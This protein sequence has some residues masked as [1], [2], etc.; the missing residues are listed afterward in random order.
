MWW[1]VTLRNRHGS[2]I[3][4]G[5]NN[6]NNNRPRLYYVV[7][8]CELKVDMSDVTC[9]CKIL[10]SLTSHTRRAWLPNSKRSGW[11]CPSIHASEE[12]CLLSFILSFSY[13][14][15]SVCPSVTL[16]HYFELR[17]RRLRQLHSPLSRRCFCRGHS[18]LQI[19]RLTWEASMGSF[20]GTCEPLRFRRKQR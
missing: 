13:F 3:G 16:S 19:L 15:V 12:T 7:R 17:P 1:N 5:V 2:R 18:Q 8:H 14:A 20:H 4:D 9:G 11:V 10:R 6:H